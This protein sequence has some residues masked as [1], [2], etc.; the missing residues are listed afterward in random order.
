MAGSPD[1]TADDDEAAAAGTTS[2]PVAGAPWPDP[3]AWPTEGGTGAATSPEADVS[4]PGASAGDPPV[5]EGLVVDDPQP[6][7]LYEAKIAMGTVRRGERFEATASDP[8][9][10]SGY[11][12][13]VRDDPPPPPD[14]VTAAFEAA[15]SGHRPA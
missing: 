8:K 2:P 15:E 3:V 4:D 13:L 6:V 9:V 7:R 12:R 1:R 5:P 14:A 10:L 11:A